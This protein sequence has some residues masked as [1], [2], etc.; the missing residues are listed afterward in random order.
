[1]HNDIKSVL[2]TEEEIQAKVKE[3]GEV[4]TRE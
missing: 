4:L 2:I 1:M 3:L